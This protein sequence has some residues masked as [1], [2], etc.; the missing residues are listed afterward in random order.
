MIKRANRFHGR[1]SVSK[2]RGFLAHTTHFS[3]RVGRNQQ[4]DYR[5]AVVVSKKVAKSAVVRNR[6]RRRVFE[7]IR[8][9]AMLNGKSV[10]GIVYVK[11]GSVADMDSQKLKSELQLATNKALLVSKTEPKKHN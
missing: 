10:D 11:D 2:L 6:I 5:L 3:F 4:N 1:H 9:Q 8:T 7:A